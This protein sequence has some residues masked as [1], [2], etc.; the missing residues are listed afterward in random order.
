MTTPASSNPS[1]TGK[2]ASSALSRSAHVDSFAR[3]NLPP[4][5]Q[6]PELLLDRPELRYPERLNAAEELL[7][8]MVHSGHAERPVIHSE[9]DG[10]PVSCTYRQLLVR[11]NQIAHV[12]QQDMGLVPGNRVLLR[13]PN[14]PMM[15]ACWLAVRRCG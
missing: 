13:A 12:L 9:V 10:K 2:A 5:E 3:D 14:N 11:A 1:R 8:R 6:W 7:D 4:R 15:A